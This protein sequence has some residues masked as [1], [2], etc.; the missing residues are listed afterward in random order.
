MRGDHKQKIQELVDAL[1]A[2]VGTPDFAYLMDLLKYLLETTQAEL[3]H[4]PVADF[5]KVQ[6]EAQA[7]DKLIRL[8][9]RPNIKSLTSKE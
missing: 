4:A 2:R 8:L 9:K 7:Y 1:Q 5:Q 3:V 6:G